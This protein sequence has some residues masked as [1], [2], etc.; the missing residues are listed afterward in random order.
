[1]PLPIKFLP[2]VRSR[3]EDEEILKRNKEVKKAKLGRNIVDTFENIKRDIEE[4]LSYRKDMFRVITDYDELKSYILRANQFGKLAIDTE[5]TGLDAM[6]CKIVGFSMYF[7][8]EKAI[9]VPVNHR[10][11]LTNNRL[12]NQ[13]NEDQCHELFKLLSVK[14]IFHNA[15]F[16][17]RV[18][19]HNFGV[20]LHAWWDTQ[21][22]AF[23]LGEEESHRLKDWHGK[24]ISHRK[25]KDY[26]DYYGGVPF[27]VV[28]VELAYIYAAND[29]LITFECYE[30]QARFLNDDPNTREDRR[31]LYWLYVNIEIPMIDVIVE[32]EENGVA[33]DTELLDVFHDKYH[34]LEEEALKECYE[35]IATIQDQI[36]DY[37]LK[38]PKCNLTDPITISS[39]DQLA[40]L[41]YDI[42]KCEPAPGKGP[43]CVDEG[44]MKYFEENYTL[45]VIKSIIKYRK[46]SKLTSTYIDNLYNLIDE[47]GRVH[48][49]FRSNGAVTGRMSSKEPINLQNIPSRGKTKEIRKMYV[50]QTTYR[51]VEPENNTYVLEREEE[52]EMGDGS[53]VWAESLKVG[54]K[55]SDGSIVQ[56]VRVEG[57][58]VMIDV[59]S[60]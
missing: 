52:V 46:A 36:D 41:F 21:E 38:H 37:K 26:Q 22:G 45:P 5:T 16:D 56:A 44:V 25:E 10:D 58:K 18:I 48:T 42:L 43:R 34:A 49:S 33:I 39:N 24:Y 14:L 19:L 6:R 31:E 32:L 59:T 15:T 4:T 20:M 54:E 17:I 35:V 9:Y 60:I 23:L 28:P 8:G 13:L 55:L 53:W 11:Y 12:E 51:D 57:F 50:G 30:F 40:T 29:A 2:E 7:P 47:T 3:L 1:M 27:A